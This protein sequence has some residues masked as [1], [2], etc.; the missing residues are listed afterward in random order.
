[1][2]KF[3]RQAMWDF[4][5]AGIKYNVKYYI[6]QCEIYQ[7]VKLENTKLSRLP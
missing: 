6:R 7:Q 5:Q 1:M 4:Y 2:E 3:L